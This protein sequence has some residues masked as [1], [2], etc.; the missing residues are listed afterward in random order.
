MTDGRKRIFKNMNIQTH[1]EM[2]QGEKERVD[3]C[4]KRGEY[5]REIL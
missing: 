3:K 1:D 4:A 5:S 2:T